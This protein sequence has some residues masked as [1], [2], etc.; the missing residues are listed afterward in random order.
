MRVGPNEKL[1]GSTS[2][3]CWLEAL[4]K[5]S[6]LNCVSGTVA[7][8]KEENG[9]PELEL[10]GELEPQLMT[11]SRFA[12]SPKDHARRQNFTPEFP[13]LHIRSSTFDKVH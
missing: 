6:E 9:L 4:V 11:K 13:A 8:E 2:V 10:E 5:L 1:P 7:G 12:L 3:A